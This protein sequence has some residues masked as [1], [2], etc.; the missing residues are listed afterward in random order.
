MQRLLHALR[1]WVNAS[2]LDERTDQL[3]QD[4]AA[5][6]VRL[7]A[8]GSRVDQLDADA[9]ALRWYNPR[10]R[11]Q[12]R[13]LDLQRAEVQAELAAIQPEG[14]RLVA[15]GAAIKAAGRHHLAQMFGGILT[16]QALTIGGYLAVGGAVAF[17]FPH[18]IHT[19]YYTATATIAP[20][21]L[22]GGLVQIAL[23][24]LRTALPFMSFAIP[25]ITAMAAS[26][27]VL[28]DHHST[29]ITFA[30]TSWGLISTALAMLLIFITPLPAPPPDTATG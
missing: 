28:A 1:R 25:A 24:R 20:V 30:L 3:V 13:L 18:T 8:L 5:L 4:H 14:H 12:R 23:G 10:R 17:R 11:P 16:L 21:L 9:R 6:Q 22:L 2:A 29:T 7:D 27:V 26:L 19:D 15:E